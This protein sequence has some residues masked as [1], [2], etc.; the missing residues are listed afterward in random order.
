MGEPLPSTVKL[1]LSPSITPQTFH[2]TDSCGQPE[3]I[4]IGRQIEVAL[5][6]GARRT[7]KTVVSDDD[8]GTA[9][10]SDHV[11]RIDI[12]DWFFAL[13]KDALYDRAPATMRMNAFARMY[14]MTGTLLRETEFKVVRQERLRLERLGK[15]CGYIIDSFIE[16]TAIELAYKLFM[17]ARVALGG[18]PAPTPVAEAPIPDSP[19]SPPAITAPASPSTLRFKALLLDENGNLIFEGGEHVRVRVDIVNTGPTPILNAS[20]SITG[21]PAVIGQFPATTLTIPSLQPGETKSLEFVAT[22]PPSLQPQQVEIRV[23]ITEAGGA[24]A[25]PQTLLFIIQPAGAETR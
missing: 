24:A 6:E 22:L 17:D 8:A 3:E 20:A 11:I 5:R 7:F 19:G 12:R 23:S 9:V 16:N 21:T 4:P 1:E 25:R 10:A 2:Y 14:D 18:P 15:N 13:D